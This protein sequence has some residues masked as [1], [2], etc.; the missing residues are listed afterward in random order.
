MPNKR[1]S[2]KFNVDRNEIISMIYGVICL[3]YVYL[4]CL[5][6]VGAVETARDSVDHR[7]HRS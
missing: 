7:F 5:L 1:L 3:M 4:L 2:F 6:L